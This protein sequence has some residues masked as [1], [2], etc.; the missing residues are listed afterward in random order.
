M[1]AKILIDIFSYCYFQRYSGYAFDTPIDFA[2]AIII[3][4]TPL[5]RPSRSLP[6]FRRRVRAWREQI[7]VPSISIRQLIAIR[8]YGG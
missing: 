6:A 3:A 1:R 8:H 5:F 4:A 2:A 7:I